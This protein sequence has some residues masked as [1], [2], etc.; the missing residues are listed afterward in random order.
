MCFSGETIFPV[1]DRLKS[2]LAQRIWRDTARA[3]DAPGTPTQSNISP[4][5]LVYEDQYLEV[6]RCWFPVGTSAYN[7]DDHGTERPLRQADESLHASG[8]AGG[9][10]GGHVDGH[11]DG[12]ADGHAD[13]HSD[14][15]AGGHA[16]GHAGT[17]QVGLAGACCGET[18]RISVSCVTRRSHPHLTPYTHPGDNIR[19][20]GTSQKWTLL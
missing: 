13:G 8:H 20:N 11:S 4:S 12:H 16:D 15:H 17:R 9:H 5:I 19:A 2:W 14:G 3:E 7:S 6:M 10:E 18:R 1:V